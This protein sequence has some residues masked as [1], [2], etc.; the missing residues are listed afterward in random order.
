MSGP[1]RRWS[2]DVL[3]LSGVSVLVLLVIWSVVHWWPAPT[4][5]GT[6]RAQESVRLGPAPGQSVS[7]YL[8]GLRPRL[9]AAGARP[10]P[11][12]IQFA[13]ERDTEDVAALL[14]AANATAVRVVFRVPLPRVQTALRFE[15]LTDV[16]LPN[17][18]EAS[19]RRLDLARDA[20]QGQAAA[21]A[22]RAT[23]RQRAVAR[24][25]AVELA[26]PCRCVLAVLAVGDRAALSTLASRP[27]VRA[28]DA[29]P[30]G[31]R[32]DEVAVTPL[33]P[34]QTGTVGPMP[35]DGPVLDVP[36]VPVS[37]GGSG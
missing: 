20:A 37:P 18:L 5:G 35:D 11:A 14:A 24:Y 33:L 15:Q 32:P 7:D 26:G 6:P 17:P 27:G 10:V 28:V 3:T 1:D 8:D 34:E 23:G 13:G 9:P 31:A 12:L 4:L 22:S 2:R 29:A 30:P 21:E 19:R 16:D 36:D 25:E